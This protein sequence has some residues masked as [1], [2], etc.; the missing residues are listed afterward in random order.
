MKSTVVDENLSTTSTTVLF[1]RIP[2]ISKI[3]STEWEIYIKQGHIEK[4]AKLQ[5]LVI[6]NLP[7]FLQ[8]FSAPKAHFH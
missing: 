3:E 5:K 7:L 4:S 8:A 6:K 2:T 1:Q